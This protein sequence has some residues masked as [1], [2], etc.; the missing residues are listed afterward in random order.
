MNLRD[1]WDW[2]LNNPPRVLEDSNTRLGRLA[3]EA[4]ERAVL[5]EK[6]A[7]IRERLGAAKA[8]IA[9]VKQK[10]GAKQRKNITWLITVVVVAG[11]LFVMLKDCG[12]A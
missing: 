7:E 6:E 10:M 12:G 4:E 8:R 5:L 2:L 3:K 9:K 11:M 1:M